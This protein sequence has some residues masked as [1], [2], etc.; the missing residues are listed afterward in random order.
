MLGNRLYRTAPSDPRWNNPFNP[1]IKLKY[2]DG[3]RVRRVPRELA[4]KRGK[5]GKLGCRYAPRD[6]NAINAGDDQNFEVALHASHE[7]RDT[8]RR[9][10]RLGALT[11]RRLWRD[12][13]LKQLRGFAQ[14]LALVEARSEEA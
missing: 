9:A 7:M 2:F 14:A 12:A 5:S 13:P 8:L 4:T 11:L 1:R 6:C 3:E 10:R